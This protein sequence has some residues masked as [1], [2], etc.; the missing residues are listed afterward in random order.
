M[1]EQL[2]AIAKAVK[3]HG[4]AGEIV[5]EVLTD[6]P[7]RFSYTERVFS[8]S[9]KGKIQGLEI[10]DFWFQK[11]R[12]VLK[13]VGI[14]S[15]EE[16]EKLIGCEICIHE[17]EVVELE[18]DEFFYWQLIGCIVETVQGERIGEVKEV[19]QGV[20]SEILV[21]QGENKDYL[22]P[23]VNAICPEVDIEKKIIKIDA[24][25]GLLDF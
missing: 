24:P 15:I 4:L 1:R 20:A 10:E 5:A 23:F 6:F 17:S 18:E 19:M 8:V 21:V 14:D 12:V 9:P 25:E 3:T 13:F 22:I 2:V 11:N 7:E 16:A